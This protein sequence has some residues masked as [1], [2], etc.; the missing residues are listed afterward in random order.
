MV[1][2]S[3]TRARELSAE[4]VLEIKHHKGS[5]QQFETENG[6]GLSLSSSPLPPGDQVAGGEQT[7]RQC[8]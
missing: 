3:S 8:V 2:V 6:H 4:E 5:S 1:D 7:A